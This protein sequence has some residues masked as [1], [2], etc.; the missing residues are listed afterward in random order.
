MTKHSLA[1]E[2][3]AATLSEPSALSK[4]LAEQFETEYDEGA[5]DVSDGSPLGMYDES[6]P[7]FQEV[8]IADGVDS[9]AA[10]LNGALPHSHS[11]TYRPTSPPTS[12]PPTKPR[13]TY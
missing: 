8:N 9:F 5:E 10:Q 7:Q 3:A 6:A 1:W 2:K 4:L 11:K 12:V 13:R